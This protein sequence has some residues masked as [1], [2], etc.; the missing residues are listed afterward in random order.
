MIA[1]TDCDLPLPETF[2][3]AALDVIV[4]RCSSNVPCAYSESYTIFFLQHMHSKCV[5]CGSFPGGMPWHVWKSLMDAVAEAM[6]YSRLHS[7]R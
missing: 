1:C 2:G 5:A 7:T 6:Y 4:L 3:T